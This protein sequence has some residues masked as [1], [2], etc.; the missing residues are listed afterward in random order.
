MRGVVFFISFCFFLL[1]YGHGFSFNTKDMRSAEVNTCGLKENTLQYFR[2]N[3]TNKVAI[4]TDY[5]DIELEE[6]YHNNDENG[7]T[8]QKTFLVKSSLLANWYLAFSFPL[9]PNSYN[10]NFNT[11]FCLST[12]PIYIKNRVLRI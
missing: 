1:G 10:T 9:L 4:V 12:S 7:A 8:D 3:N 2:N 5:T 6:D 11:S